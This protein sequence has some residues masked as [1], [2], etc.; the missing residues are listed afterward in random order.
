MRNGVQQTTTRR[1][2]RSTVWATGLFASALLAAPATLVGQACLGEAPLPGQ[3]TIG[4]YGAFVDDAKAYGVRSVS[5]LTGPV[6][7]GARIGVIDLDDVSDDIT[8]LGG[9]LAF[10]ASGAR[11]LSV[12]PAIGV[13]H[14]FWSGTVAGVDLDHTRWAFPAALAAGARVGG[15]AGGASLIPAARLGAIHQRFGGTASSGP[16]TFQ[17]E[18]NRTDLFIDAGATLHAGPLYLRGG[19]FRIFQDEAETVLRIGAGVV[20]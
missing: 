17:R 3:F 8:S 16:I 19:I 4:G 13:E 5:N 11:P 7:L 18:G 9:H 6:A 15:E 14:D 2:P 1:A 10:E 20:F 12:C